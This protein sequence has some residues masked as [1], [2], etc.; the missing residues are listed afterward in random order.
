[1]KFRVQ[2]LVCGVVDLGFRAEGLM[3]RVY[4]V[5]SSGLHS[6]I[7]YDDSCGLTWDQGM[8]EWLRLWGYNPV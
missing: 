5:E 6:P 7:Q 8:N 1:M 3:V 4:R 2:D